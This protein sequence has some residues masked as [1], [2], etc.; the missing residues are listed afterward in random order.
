VNQDFAM[1]ATPAIARRLLHLS[2]VSNL[3]LPAELVALASQ[4]CISE[5]DFDPF[6]C[7]YSAERLT[8]TQFLLDSDLRGI[9]QASYHPAIDELTL[10]NVVRLAHP[11]KTTIVTTRR[12]IWRKAANAFALADLAITSPYEM[13]GH[14]I[15]ARRDGALIFDLENFSPQRASPCNRFVREFPHIIL[16]QPDETDVQQI[17][18]WTALATLLF[19][20]M[21]EP[22]AWSTK[23]LID[24]VLFYNVCFF[25]EYIKS[26][27]LLNIAENTGKS[28][29]Y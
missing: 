28:A 10:L 1:H 26:T 29:T 20:T 21:P 17:H 8:I 9:V 23:R 16:Y 3:K 24:C 27:E 6:V 13:T 11:S 18:H 2:H 15:D 4:D 7:P 5:I 25:P 22:M 14:Q 19:P 12:A